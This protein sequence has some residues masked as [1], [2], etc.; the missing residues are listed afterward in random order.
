MTDNQT[1]QMQHDALGKGLAALRRRVGLSGSDLARQIGWAQSKV[2]KIENAKQMPTR[3]D[4]EAWGLAC[5]ATESEIDAY[6]VQ[7]QALQVERMEWRH[8]AVGGLAPVQLDY[9]EL[10]ARSTD[11]RYFETAFVPGYLQT[12]AYARRI[13]SEMAEL[14]DIHGR[15]DDAAVAAR[16]RRQQHLYDITKSFTFLV[17]EPVLMWGMCPPD[18]MRPQLD[19]ILSAAELPNVTVAVLPMRRPIATTPQHPFQLYDDLAIV[20]LITT[21]LMCRADEAARYARVFDRLMADAVTGREALDL[22]K[23][24]MQLLA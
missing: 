9:D 22:I 13:L 11:I 3:A 7:L 21:E 14:H 8:R 24:A 10:A 5:S 1:S 12:A 16:L 6:L 19:R 17:A 2:S 23:G 15:D 20:D 4:V 18:V